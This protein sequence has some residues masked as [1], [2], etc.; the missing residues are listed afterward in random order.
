MSGT[1]LEDM[2]ASGA[3]DGDRDKVK[4]AI[5]PSANWGSGKLDQ[6]FQR[7]VFIR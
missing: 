6:S 5:K 2:A 1:R 4:V 3:A 7:G